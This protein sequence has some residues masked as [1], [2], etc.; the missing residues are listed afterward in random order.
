MLTRALIVWLALLGL[1]ILNGGAREAFIIPRTGDL[2]GH[3][4]S[5]ITLCLAILALSWFSINWI[6][7]ASVRDAW[8]IGAVWVALTLAFEFLAGHY[9]FGNPWSRLLADYDIFR[10]RIW[11]LV[12]ATTALA[13]ALSA[14][15]RGVVGAR[16]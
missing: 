3:L 10:G 5:T 16:P 13:P 6:H 4:L 8:T 11:V 1:A 9:L 15:A 12:L 14:Y 2:R 7:P